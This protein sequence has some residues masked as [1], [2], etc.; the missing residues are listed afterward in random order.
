MTAPDNYFD[1]NN[2]P[3]RYNGQFTPDPSEETV[4]AIDGHE[5][6]ISTI[7]DSVLNEPAFT[8][9]LDQAELSVWLAQKR[10]HCTIEGNLG[11]TLAAALIAG[12]LAVLGAMIKG[13]DLL[14]TL[15]PIVHIIVKAFYIILYGPV[16]EEFLKQSGMIYLLE[17]KP[18]RV[19]SSAQIIIAAVISAGLFASIEN[20]LYIHLYTKGHVFENFN[21]YCCFRWIVCTSLHLVCSI[22][23][24]FGL[25]KIWKKQ[26]AD[27]RAADL[28]IGFNYFVTAIAIH[29]IYNLA[30]TVIHPTF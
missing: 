6:E 18:Y 2:E 12:S 24:S 9:H 25:I 14:F 27:G 11:V 30:A 8:G 7:R 28:S 3:A 10:A 20:L 21:N 5:D 29:G 22:I 4:P 1:I 26:L 17:K 23:A 15:N 13:I 19:F 16:V